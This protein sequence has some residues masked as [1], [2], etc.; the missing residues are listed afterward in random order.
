MMDIPKQLALLSKRKHAH[1]TLNGKAISYNE[2]FDTKGL[3]PP[4]TRRAEQV[5]SLCFGYKLG[6]KFDEVE[7]GITGV[8]VSFDDVTPESLRMMC[9]LDVLLE[10][11]DGSTDGGVVTL[12]DLMYE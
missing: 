2:V 5:A 6:A 9:L 10:I 1:F 3:L 7:N 4:M 12:D 8:E 11:L